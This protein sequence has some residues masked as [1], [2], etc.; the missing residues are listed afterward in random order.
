MR[1]DF[2]AL[3]PLER[4]TRIGGVDVREGPV[5]RGGLDSCPVVTTWMRADSRRAFVVAGD[6]RMLVTDGERVTI[7]A[8][9]RQARSTYDFLIYSWALR[10]LL[11][12]RGEHALHASVVAHRSGVTLAIAGDSGAGKSTA[13]SEL[14]LR[15][16]QLVAD[17]I[18]PVDV[19]A[20][21]NT[22]RPVERPVHLSAAALRRLGIDR[23][24]ARELP[25]RGRDGRTLKYVVRLAADLR[26]R[27][28]DHLAIVG[29]R[30]EGPA[31][32]VAHP[33]RSELIPTVSDL[34][35][36]SG[37]GLLPG[38]REGLVG[39]ASRMT[40]TPATVITRLN[41]LDTVELITDELEHAVDVR[42]R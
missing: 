30:R 26:P 35:A 38:L 12:Q 23:R 28:L 27:T 7:D 39:W 40:R 41:Q 17:D 20:G 9:D 42:V 22:V 14:L 36:G 1:C 21:C 13:V 31:V 19:S 15:G 18:A 10:L 37:I 33:T 3:A 29:V 16:W 6:V 25:E 5:D 32:Q 8:P 34:A 4:T 2:G 11:L 24:L